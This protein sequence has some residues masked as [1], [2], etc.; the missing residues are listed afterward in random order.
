M[1]KLLTT[2]DYWQALHG[3]VE[4][5]C[6]FCV[7]AG[8]LNRNTV[9]SQV[10][11]ILKAK[12]FWHYDYVVLYAAMEILHSEGKEINWIT[13]IPLLESAGL[14]EQVGGW[15]HLKKFSPLQIQ[16]PNQDS[17]LESAEKIRIASL[18]R[19]KRNHPGG[20]MTSWGEASALI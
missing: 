6:E 15:N 18:E 19:E 9:S 11:E 3:P 12:D 8:L 4:V 2:E 1:P 7:M 17:I 16:L 14:F 5:K 13:I 10:M 20:F